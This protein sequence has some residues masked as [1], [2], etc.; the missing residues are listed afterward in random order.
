MMK[1]LRVIGWLFLIAVLSPSGTL[2]APPGITA[3][4]AVL[5]DA[6]TGEVLFSRDMHRRMEPASTTKVLTAIVA[7]EKGDLSQ[8]VKVSEKA[9]QTEGSSIWLEAGEVESLYDL[10]NGLLLSSGND[11]AVSIAENLAGTEER[12]TDWMNEKARQLGATDSHFANT[13]GLPDPAHYTSVY[14]MALIARYALVN[15]TFSKIVGTRRHVMPWPGHEWDRAMTNHN[16]LLWRYDGADGVKTGYTRSAGHCLVASATRD[17]HRLL[18]VVFKSRDIYS[19]SAALFDWGFSHFSLK[20]FARRTDA[21][22]EIPIE[23]GVDTKAEVVPAADLP[24]VLDEFRLDEAEV[25]I[26][27]PELVGA[28]LLRRQRVG[29]L[30]VKLRGEVIGQVDL[31]AKN[32]VPRRTLLLTII[33]WIR[34]LFGAE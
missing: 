10:L 9:S 31:V 21:V 19:D 34:T 27:L 4:S 8:P 14:D 20:W 15:P 5:M 23:G 25:E 18:A 30:R 7:L 2:A 3:P 12:F 17:G 28:P 1:V 16:K 32:E 22:G 33:G 11:A 29:A 26:A 13:N 6:T 24:L